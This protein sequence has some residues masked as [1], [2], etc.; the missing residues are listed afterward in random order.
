MFLL[1]REIAEAFKANT[2]A[3]EALTETLKGKRSPLR[4]DSVPDLSPC[5]SL[6]VIRATFSAVSARLGG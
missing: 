6:I 3:R 4:S 2:E 1:N 5:L